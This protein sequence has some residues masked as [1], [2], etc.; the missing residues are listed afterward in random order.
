MLPSSF[1]VISWKQWKLEHKNISTLN[2]P[3]FQAH[4][5]LSHT[6][7]HTFIASI[8]YSR[9]CSDC[10]HCLACLLVCLEHA[11][12]HCFCFWS[13]CCSC[14]CV[15]ALISGREHFPCWC[16]KPA[17]CEQ[18]PMADNYALLEKS[19]GVVLAC[20]LSL[21]FLPAIHVSRGIKATTWNEHSG[22]R[23]VEQR[24]KG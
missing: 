19:A 12:S 2:I 11:V 18:R 20:L 21:D 7:T 10:L 4:I 3:T 14:S 8:T 15:G 16:C 9:A 5:S 22:V 6:H 1:V 24:G 23:L 13:H 17:S